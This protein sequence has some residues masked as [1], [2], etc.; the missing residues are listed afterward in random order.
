M[1]VV[2]V[3]S[4]LA[5][6]VV[7]R[8]TYQETENSE[9][10]GDRGADEALESSGSANIDTVLRQLFQMTLVSIE[11]YRELTSL[12]AQPELR[13]FLDVIARQRTAQC[14]ALAQMSGGSISVPLNF[15]RQIYS[16]FDG[17][18]SV[19][20][21]HSWV[22]AIWTFEQDQFVRFSECLDQAETALED[23]FLT[24][25]EAF[26]DSEFGANFQQ[27]AINI[28]G[29]RQC[30]EDVTSGCIPTGRY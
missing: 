19:T 29:A 2:A 6:Q 30:L 3:P 15:E 14:R 11:G 12:A 27:Y 25:A 13:E 17:P 5:S 24:A 28:C 18:D 21:Q 4:M 20:L 9:D 8:D 10:M 23:A 7:S 1:M 26:P 16:T 22:R